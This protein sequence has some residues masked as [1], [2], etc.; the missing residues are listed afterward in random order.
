MID[1]IVTDNEKLYGSIQA[2]LS[3]YAKLGQ[4]SNFAGENTDIQVG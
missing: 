4:V 1:N 2:L 3:A